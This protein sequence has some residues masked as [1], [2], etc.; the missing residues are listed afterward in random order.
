MTTH[1]LGIP[2]ASAPAG[3]TQPDPA[4]RREQTPPRP[5]RDSDPAADP[6]QAR[7]V[8]PRTHVIPGSMRLV[9]DILDPVTRDILYRIPPQA[10]TEEVIRRG[11]RL[12]RYERLMNGSF[13][14]DRPGRFA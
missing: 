7:R 9:T 12:S 10:V 14:Q 13:L 11:E 8:E 6:A 3:T 2:P 1:D 4:G 5:T